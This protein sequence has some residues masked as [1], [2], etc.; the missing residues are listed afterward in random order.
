MIHDRLR[1]LGTALQRYGLH[2]QLRDLANA[3]TNIRGR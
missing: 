1:E 2:V 3:I